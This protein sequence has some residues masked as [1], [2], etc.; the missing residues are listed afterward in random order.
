MELPPERVTGVEHAA[1]LRHAGKIRIPA[2]VLEKPGPLDEDER[3]MV[4]EHP[5]IGARLV[6][7]VAGLS[8]LAPIIR[9]QDE[10]WDGW[11][12]PDGLQG[13]EIPLA[14]R[15]IH[16]CAAYHAMT[17]GRPYRETMRPEAAMEEL[18]TNAGTQFCPGA[19]EALLS[20]LSRASDREGLPA[21]DRRSR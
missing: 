18:E 11:G 13:E 3:R 7:Q 4:R 1:L 10:R 16:A 6:T 2:A 12:Q 5:V 8:H 19:V 14:S 21:K 20:A 17:S 15:V 9:T